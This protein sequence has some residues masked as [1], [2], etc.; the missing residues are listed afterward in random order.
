MRFDSLLREEE[1]VADLPVHKALG[2]EL[3]YLDFARRGLLFELSERRREWDHLGIPLP[4]LRRSRVEAARVVHIP[5]Q[6]LFALCGVHD[7]RI[8]LRATR[9]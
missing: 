7:P 3:Q 9:L 2:D 6:D 8:G 4:A 1:L 5:G